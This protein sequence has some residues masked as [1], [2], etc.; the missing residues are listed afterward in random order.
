MKRGL[1]ANGVQRYLCACKKTFVPTTGTIFDE[2]FTESIFNFILIYI[3]MKW[4]SE[5]IR[6]GLKGEMDINGKIA[7]FG[8]KAIGG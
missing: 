1:T 6:L 7:C 5:I 3:I 4:S 8:R 2:K